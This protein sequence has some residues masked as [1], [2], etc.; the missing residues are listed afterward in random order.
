MFLQQKPAPQAAPSPSPPPH[1]LYNPTQHMLTY[2]GFCPSG[3]TL[4]A[5]PNYPIP[6]QVGRKTRLGTGGMHDTGVDSG[7]MTSSD[8]SGQ[9]KMRIKDF[10]SLHISQHNSSYQPSAA[11]QPVPE[12]GPGPGPASNACSPEENQNQQPPQASAQPQPH[13]AGLDAGGYT[14]TP[15]APALYGPSYGPFEKP[16]PYAC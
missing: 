13:G 5:Y 11:P 8:R 1:I 9:C 16:P 4:P 7:L 6:M 3:Q 14:L 12:A 2:A 10:V 15:N